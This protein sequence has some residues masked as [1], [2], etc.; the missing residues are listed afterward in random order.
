MKA[1]NSS[2]T[3]T[4]RLTTNDQPR[5]RDPIKPP[6]KLIPFVPPKK[7]VNEKSKTENQASSYRNNN[8]EERVEI[9]LRLESSVLRRPLSPMQNSTA[10]VRGFKKSKVFSQIKSQRDDRGSEPSK[11]DIMDFDAI[12]ERALPMLTENDEEVVGSQMA[13]KS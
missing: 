9:D 7:K 4:T 6:F 8:D 2:Q 10:S 5:A 3:T 12:D 1:A 13:T 11:S